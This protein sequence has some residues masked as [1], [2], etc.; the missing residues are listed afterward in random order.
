MY[1]PPPPGGYP[2]PPPPGGYPPPPPP[3]PGYYYPPPPVFILGP[4]PRR[5]FAL[6]VLI[7][8][9]VLS[10]ALLLMALSLN[11]Q[12]DE[13]RS[14]VR[15]ANKIVILLIV[16]GIA[17]IVDAIR[18]IYGRW[19]S[20]LSVGLVQLILGLGLVVLA[21]LLGDARN[22]RLSAGLTQIQLLGGALALSG[23]LCL[24]AI[25]QVSAYGAWRRASRG[26][27]PE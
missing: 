7:V 12:V 2:P 8:A 10:G 20:A 13:G 19:K 1:P 16:C 14:E 11:G 23:T 15:L 17:G 24:C 5:S 4:E 27:P 3:P 21:L 6:P 9:A 25:G 18:A 22:I 26:L